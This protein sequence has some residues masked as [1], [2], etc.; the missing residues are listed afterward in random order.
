MDKTGI[1][2]LKKGVELGY[3]RFLAKL[4]KS[5][6]S[7]TLSEAREQT[8]KRDGLIIQLNR[9]TKDMDGENTG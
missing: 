4:T 2:S 7:K 6:K 8:D 9:V 5:L 1:T 3:L